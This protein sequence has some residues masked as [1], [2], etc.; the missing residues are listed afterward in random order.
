MIRLSHNNLLALME[1]VPE[2]LP[3]RP[4]Y[5]ET[6]MPEDPEL[7]EGVWGEIAT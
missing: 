2:V 7:Y 3:Y 1:A 6:E 5:A 4:D